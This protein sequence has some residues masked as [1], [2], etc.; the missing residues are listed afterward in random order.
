MIVHKAHINLGVNISYQKAWRAKEHIVKILKGDA[1]ESYTLIPNFFDE[2]VESNPCTCTNLE[3]D[4]SD[5]FK[6]CF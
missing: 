3:I 4:D 1:V 5:H 6:F 2:L